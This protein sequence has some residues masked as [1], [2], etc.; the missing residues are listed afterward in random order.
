[1]K[2][3]FI[4]LLTSIA[5]LTSGALF[6]QT[7]KG[8]IKADGSNSQN[9]I[10]YGK[11]TALIDKQVGNINICIS[12]PDQTLSS[13]TNPTDAQ[14]TKVVNVANAK[15]DN[16]SIV[17][18][19][20]IGG[21]AY[22]TYL[23]FQDAGTDVSANWAAD[24]E[25]PILTLTF[26]SAGLLT[27]VRINDLTSAA[28]GSNGQMYWYVQFNGLGDVTDYTSPFY[29]SGAVNSGGAA[30]QYVGL[31]PAGNVP[32]RFLDF[33]AT[34]KDDAAVL[35][36]QIENESATT[37]R[38]EVERSVNGVD[39][40]KVSTVNALNNGNSSNVYST[41]DKNISTVRSNGILYYRIKQID[42]NGKY[43]YTVIKS[44]RITNKNVVVGVY[45]NPVKT[46]ANVTIDVTE[47]KNVS[48]FL[49]D[50]TG[51][52]IKKFSMVAQKGLNTK[53]I[54]MSNLANGNYL[55]KVQ[56]EEEV[57]TLSVVKQ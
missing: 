19:T 14:I 56:T 10:V 38:Y 15:I 50:A 25:N 22:Y 33:N 45:P 1:M 49:T 6:A 36:W 27:D 42:A 54:D 8:T 53:K 12:I 30:E 24:S 20:I 16:G 9:V 52:E 31:Q 55:I 40:V 48:L 2:K 39:F 11:T 18:P 37:A 23:I 17:N 7:V 21:R 43:V 13:G 34:K 32:V 51:K 4:P 26:P 57:K 29:G 28:G 35:N 3:F 47:V 5:I 46:A 41:T 44:V